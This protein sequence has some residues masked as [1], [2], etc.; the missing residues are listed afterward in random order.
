MSASGEGFKDYP[1]WSSKPGFVEALPIRSTSELIDLALS[2]RLDG[3]V[4]FVA[5]VATQHGSQDL[6]VVFNADEYGEPDGEA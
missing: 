6:M 1:D 4:A 3:R 2:Q 5:R